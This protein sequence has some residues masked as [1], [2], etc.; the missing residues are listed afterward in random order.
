MTSTF[1]I[2]LNK[3]SGLNLLIEAKL[4]SHLFF[5]LRNHSLLVTSV[6]SQFA[7][8]VQ[9]IYVYPWSI[10]VCIHILRTK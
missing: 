6:P 3:H 2:V 5:L 4:L 10:S 7:V 9:A 1:G 8:V